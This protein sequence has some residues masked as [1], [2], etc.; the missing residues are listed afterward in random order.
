MEGRASIKLPAVGADIPFNSL[1]GLLSSPPMSRPPLPDSAPIWSAS[2]HPEPTPPGQAGAASQVFAMVLSAGCLLAGV[3][4]MAFGYLFWEHGVNAMVWANVASV[5]A[6]AVAAVLLR[7]G[8]VASA[9]TLMMAEVT[10]HAVAAVFVVGWESGFHLYLLVV[11]PGYLA[12]QINRWPTRLA[13][14]GSVSLA[15]VLLDK[16]AH[17]RPPLH[18][19]P[20]DVLASLHVFNLATTLAL[21]CVFTVMYVQL[22]AQAERRLHELATT[23]SLTGLM[24][25]RSMLAALQ[26]LQSQRQRRPQPVALLLIDIDHFKQLNDT[27]GHAL[28]DWALQAVADVLTIGVRDV[29]MVSRWGG[30]EFLI[31]LPDTTP[32]AALQVADRLRL[33]I[34]ALRFP[35]PRGEGDP[36][37]TERE[38]TLT[39]TFGLADLAPQQSLDG[40][41]HLADVA[42]YQGKQQGRNRVVQAA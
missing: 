20:P 10:L 21:L 42:L 32:E 16:F 27:H 38:Q 7:R 9:M 17:H 30:E 14:A 5:C 3:C 11:I 4:H 15:Y 34:A 22:I 41:I 26:R 31:A 13:V 18:P 39:A 40:A 35:L 37:G 19:I 23:D 25:R 1:N 24:N 36:E 33:N 12:N 6:Y 8:R 29:D 2:T 28:G